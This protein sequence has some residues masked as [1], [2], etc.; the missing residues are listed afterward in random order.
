MNAV[1]IAS[2]TIE[3]NVTR[4]ISQEIT[5]AD[6]RLDRAKSSAPNSVPA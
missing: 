6:E 2:E 3:H 4:L 5:R 1:R